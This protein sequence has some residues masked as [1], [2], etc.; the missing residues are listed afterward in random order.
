MPPQSKNLTLDFEKLTEKNLQPIV[1]LFKTAGYTVAAI[2]APNKGK[3]ESGMLIKRFTLT[4]EDGQNVEA[5]VKSDGTIFQVRLNNKVVPIKAVDDMKKAVSEI[6]NYL[7]G[8]AKSFARAKAQREKAKIR[9]PK[10]K[11]TTSRAE[12]IAELSENLDQIAQ[13]VADLEKEVEAAKNKVFELDTQLDAAKAE[14][15]R[16]RMRTTELEA[17]IARLTPEGV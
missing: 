4:F 9:P 14:L 16:E 10:P 7:Y 12:K 5:R 13:N 3:R 15:A 17:E 6:A 2:D 8:N 1:K 11:I